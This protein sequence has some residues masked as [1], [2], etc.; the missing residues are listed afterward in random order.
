MKQ[1]PRKIKKPL[2]LGVKV[3]IWIVVILLLW[4]FFGYVDFCVRRAL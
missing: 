3:M 4:L 2:K 1:K